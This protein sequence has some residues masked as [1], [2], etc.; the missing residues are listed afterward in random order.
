[1][2]AVPQ[3]ARQFRFTNKAFWRNPASA[4]FTFAFPLMFLV[5]F[6]S[7]LGDEEL[8]LQGVELSTTTYYVGAMAAFGVISA[9]FTNIAISTTFNRDAGILK[10]LRG[11]PIPVGA[12]LTSRVLHAMVVGA[13]LVVITLLFGKIVYDSPLPT[14]G[15]LLE[16]I[17]SFVVGAL[18]FAALALAL[19]AAVPN[20]DAAPPVV[21]AVVL[22]LLFLSGIF[23]PLDDGA[24][25]WMKTVA[26]IFPVKHF[27]DAMRAGFL[28]NLTAPTPVGTVR[29]FPFDW[30]DIAIIAAW[31]LLGLVLATRVFS[32]EP[33]R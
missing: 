5:I 18:S 27:A 6:T 25:T 28:G 1:M 24:P 15:P 8:Q 3:V 16:F 2:S 29:A 12:Y 21:N 32:W 14:G 20:A 23:F 17:V 7:L 30:W 33:R 10:R 9:C 11:T 19:T 4:F 31:G 22:P 26:D 13:I